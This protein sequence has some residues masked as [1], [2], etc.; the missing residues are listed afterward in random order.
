ME[1]FVSPPA[2]KKRIR[3]RTEASDRKKVKGDIILPSLSYGLFVVCQIK[4]KRKTS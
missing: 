3:A 2:F 1:V 4:K